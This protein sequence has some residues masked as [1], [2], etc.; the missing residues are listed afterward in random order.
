[1]VC[2]N[3]RA[4]KVLKCTY[5]NSFPLIL[6]SLNCN[7]HCYTWVEYT[8]KYTNYSSF[9]LVLVS[10]KLSK[11]TYYTSFLFILVIVNLSYREVKLE[12]NIV[13][14]WSLRCLNVLIIVVSINFSEVKVCFAL[15]ILGINLVILLY[16][17]L[18]GAVI[19]IVSHWFYW[20]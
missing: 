14:L 15:L 3:F 19:I 2:S 8:S 5:N 16:F 12:W 1:M 7:L 20:V 9:H 10:I 11:C 17:K 4:L 13:I 6:V 18:L